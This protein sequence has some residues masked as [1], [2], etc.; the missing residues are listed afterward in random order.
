MAA[1]PDDD[2]WPRFERGGPEDLDRPGVDVLDQN[3]WQALVAYA[4]GPER[5]RTIPP[6]ANRTVRVTTGRRVGDAWVET[7]HEEPLS[8]ADDDDV[9]GAMADFLANAG[10]PP[11]PRDVRWVLDLPDGMTQNEFWDEV[12]A[13]VDPTWDACTA[14]ANSPSPGPTPF[15]P[16]LD[17]T[18]A[19]LTRLY[20]QG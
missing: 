12:Y 2:L 17:A 18:N 11:P 3:G 8:Q 6:E 5:C 16:L 13:S 14:V 7:V 15:G 4:A 1:L 20:A 19:V 9:Y 10:V